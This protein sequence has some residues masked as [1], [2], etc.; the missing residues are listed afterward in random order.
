MLEWTVKAWT[1]YNTIL[2]KHSLLCIIFDLIAV[3]ITSYVLHMLEL[4]FFYNQQ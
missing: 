4:V 3:I 2:N 1:I